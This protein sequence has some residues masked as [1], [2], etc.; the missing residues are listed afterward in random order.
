MKY[1]LVPTKGNVMS[2]EGCCFYGRNFKCNEARKDEGIDSNDLDC[3]GGGGKYHIVVEVAD[4][5]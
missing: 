5:S 2:C 3:F 1:K 4:E